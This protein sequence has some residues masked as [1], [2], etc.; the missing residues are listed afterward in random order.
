MRT[1]HYSA[2]PFSQEPREQ[3]SLL[4]GKGSEAREPAGG[5]FSSQIDEPMC[6]CRA[7]ERCA[8]RSGGSSAMFQCG[9]SSAGGD[10]A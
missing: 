4:R 7:E 8:A 6:Q 1:V 2:N 10:P 5:T 9:A 3:K